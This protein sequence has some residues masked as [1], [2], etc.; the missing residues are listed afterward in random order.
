M[1]RHKIVTFLRHY[2]SI[3][4]SVKRRKLHFFTTTNKKQLQHRMRHNE[5][6]GTEATEA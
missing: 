6:G 2:V 3:Y 5:N 4:A 1:A